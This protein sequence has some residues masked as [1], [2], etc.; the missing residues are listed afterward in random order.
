MPLLFLL[1]KKKKIVVIF[2][3]LRPD[4]TCT[5]LNA[6]YA[7]F[8]WSL[9]GYCGRSIVHCK[10][11][12]DL[13]A[14]GL[15]GIK[16]WVVQLIYK[17]TRV[18]YGKN[19]GIQG[20]IRGS[21]SSSGRRLASSMVRMEGCRGRKVWMKGGGRKVHGSCKRGSSSSSVRRLASSTVRWK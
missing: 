12:V 7:F 4:Q 2:P 8:L 1:L 15:N 21:S 9:W 16:E 18:Q 6:L 11:S 13:R 19:E 20:I 3:L 5:L 10:S 17:K 14:K